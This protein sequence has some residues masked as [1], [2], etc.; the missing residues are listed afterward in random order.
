LNKQTQNDTTGGGSGI[1]DRIGGFVEARSTWVILG[2]VLITILLL[3]PLTQMA[4]D[5]MAE[6]NPGG[7]VYD[8]QETIDETMPPSV[9]YTFIIAESKDTD[10]LSQR[11]LW[12]LYQN[13]ERLRGSELG[14]KY[15]YNRYDVAAQRPVMGVYSIADAVAHFLPQNLNTTLEHATDDQVKLAIHYIL[16]DPSSADLKF[17]MSVKLTSEKRTVLDQSINYYVSP[18]VNFGI[19]SDNGLIITDYK[20]NETDTYDNVIAR[21]YYDREVVDLLRG[22]QKT[23]GLWGVAIDINLE[24]EEEG[25]LSF[26]LIGAAII[27]IL[28]IVAVQ[29]RSP[30][31][32]GLTFVGLMML[33]I[34]LM[35]LTNLVG[36]HSSLTMDII[37]PVAI[38]VLG[39]DY[40]IHALHR[41]EEEKEHTGIP[42]KALKLGVAG[43]GGALFLAMITTVVAFASNA[44]SKIE[45]IYEFGFGTALAIV[46][47][48]IIMGFFIPVCKMRIDAYRFSKKAGKNEN[49]PDLSRPKK[50][51]FGK[52][53]G[54]IVIGIAR[55][56]AVVLP[57][58]L[59]ISILAGY[60]AFQLEAELDAKEFFS[61]ES[62]FVVSLDKLDQHLG[63]KGG[64]PAIFYIKGDLTD[65]EAISAIKTFIGNMEDNTHV[66]R[67]EDDGTANVNDVL[68]EFMEAIFTYNYTEHAMESANPGLDITDSN[69]DSIPDTAE[70]LEAVY[71]YMHDIGVPINA[72]TLLYEPSQIREQLTIKTED[73]TT[74]YATLI[75]VGV[76]DTRQQKTVEDSE[77][78]FNEDMKA[79]DVPSITFYGMTGSGYQRVASLSAVTYSLNLSIIVAVVLCFSVLVIILRSFK[80][81]L[82]TVIPEILV[83]AWLYA[84]MFIAGYHLN[85][86]T[87]T[88]ASISIGVGI[89]YSVHVTA[90]FRQELA[91]IGDKNKAMER[92]AR[93]SGAALL[94]SA[95]S[96][97]F[98]FAIIGFAPM[99]MFSSFGILT[100]IMILMAFVAALLVL[101][102]L[103]ILVTGKKEEVS[104]E[105]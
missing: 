91:K 15:L 53:L 99:P 75:W 72:T 82:V 105:G 5:R 48:F 31:V 77:K 64:E 49:A 104:S 61:P 37:V 18:A 56:R 58:I 62:D 73:G 66:A 33:I 38:M 90:R 2:I 26:P 21:E 95:A 6:D 84:F 35:G 98:G 20:N 59:V 68:F 17:L 76:P 30:L 8:L 23:Y 67:D 92:A 83:A 78:E 9:H 97:M 74:E 93:F 85:I 79:L 24:S 7:A 71:H 27:L 51:S 13:E 42:R 32:M 55:K 4:P 14:Q 103:L 28:I 87:A 16:E 45:S 54:R 100:A 69:N 102:S 3:F 46:A 41:Y 22:S 94:G 29:F 36:I 50:R 60:F 43:V 11:E 1:W 34:W 25:M 65:P 44:T 81:A 63:E 80:Y 47:A 52:I 101:P 70:Q 88:I 19:N 89:D 40:V 57:V 39:V 12:E 96:T 10:I 86:V